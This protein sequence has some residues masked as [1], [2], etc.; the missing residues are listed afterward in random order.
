V[1]TTTKIFGLRALLARLPSKA[2]EV[3]SEN[4]AG[5]FSFFFKKWQQQ[6]FAVAQ[7]Q[8]SKAI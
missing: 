3:C 7:N 4:R 2:N 6:L 8:N 1:S 5:K